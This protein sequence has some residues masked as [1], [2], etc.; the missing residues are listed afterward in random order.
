MFFV[1]VQK[2][3]W[4]LGPHVSNPRSRWFLFGKVQ[5]SPSENIFCFLISNSRNYHILHCACITVNEILPDIS[6]NSWFE[7][8]EIRHKRVQRHTDT[9][10]HRHTDIEIKRLKERKQERDQQN[11]RKRQGLRE[12]E[13]ERESKREREKH[14]RTHTHT[15]AQIRTQLRP[16]RHR[17][18]P[19]DFES[20]FK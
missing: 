9:Q 7:F 8:D 14:T 3:G 5:I 20:F 2:K 19:R 10:T 4:K 12:R 6:S 1:P 11:E 15:H 16:I 17:N 18:I 13:R